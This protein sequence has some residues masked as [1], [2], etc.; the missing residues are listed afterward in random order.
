MHSLFLLL[1][2]VLTQ[3]CLVAAMGLLILFVCRILIYIGMPD[4]V[5]MLLTRQAHLFI[6][7]QCDW[8]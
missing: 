4:I 2:Y 3:I 7:W 8:A 1:T 5:I 6:D